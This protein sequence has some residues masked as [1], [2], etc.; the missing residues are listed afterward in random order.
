MKQNDDG[1]FTVED[2]DLENDTDAI[3]VDENIDETFKKELHQTI[4]KK[5]AWREKAID[6]ESKKSYKELYESVKAQKPNETKEVV[7][8]KKVDT[9]AVPESVLSDIASL[10]TES[11][12]RVFQHANNLSPTQVDEVFAY[13][14][15][16]NIEPK[17][18][19]EKPFIKNV[20]DQMTADDNASN[21][22]L[23]PSRKAP[24]QSGGKSFKDMTT[25]ERKEMFN[26]KK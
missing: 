1:T 11:Q 3:N 21:A 22:T 2:T 10:K 25:E 24:L 13:A 20:L 26:R 19:M 6:P 8:T 23:R 16:M 9:T 15:G 17:I 4:A 14:K 7:E 12:K 18:A 5:K